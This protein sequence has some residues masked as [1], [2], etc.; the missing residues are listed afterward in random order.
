MLF[1]YWTSE[2]LDAPPSLDAW[3]AKYPGFRVF[4]DADV[5]P[6]LGSDLR[7]RIYNEITL[8][9]CKSD[10]ARLVLLREYGG[11]YVDAHTGPSDGERLA[12]T[13]E[14]LATYELVLFCRMYMAKT[15]EE[16]HLMNGALVGRRKTPLLDDL[17]N[18]AFD[19]LVQHKLAEQAT[20]D[21]VHYTL[22]DLAGTWILLKSFFD[23]SSKPYDL[24]P[25]F[26][27]RILVHK[28]T[29]EASPGFRVYQFYG[30]R[31]PGQH[32]SERQKEERLFTNA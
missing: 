25:E 27:G 7:R 9:A 26:K 14:A 1:T 10:I 13:L 2:T 12:E 11:L 24:R 28:M 18:C 32:W 3:R 4:G 20:S 29:G 17:I 23:M 31:E 6:L 15:P 16:I 22:W 30:Y 21:H 19:N 5:L 8:P